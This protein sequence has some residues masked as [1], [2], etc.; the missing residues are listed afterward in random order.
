MTTAQVSSS[1]PA[2]A[3]AGRENPMDVPLATARRLL[4]QKFR[5]HGLDTPELDARILI[6]HAL[7]LDHAALVAQSGR[8]LVAAEK[9]AIAALAT[10]RLACEPVARILGRKEFWGLSFTL[11]A[12]TLVPRPE[13]EAVIEAALDALGRE[14]RSRALRVADIGTGSGALILALLSELP[15]AR[16]TGT[17]ISVT[18]LACARDNAVAFGLATRATFVACD[19]GAALKGPFDLIV[20]NPPYVARD[21]IAT[22][23]REVRDYD[24]TRALDGGRDGLDAYRPIAAEARRLLSPEGVLV[25]ELGAGQ[26]GAVTAL[27]SAAGLAPSGPPRRDLSGVA[28]A[29]LVKP[30]P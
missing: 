9:E 12:E 30:L 26:L 5:Q 17:D 22:L 19:Y 1:V 7:G 4:A 25:V 23:P 15:A 24:P 2:D 20:S 16:G 21:E 11:N 10:R 28:R 29:L 18:A 3:F 8:L 13:T 6:G 27:V 14:S